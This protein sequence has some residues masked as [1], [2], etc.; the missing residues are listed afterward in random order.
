[1]KGSLPLILGIFGTFA[2]SWTGLT[3]I[4]NAQ[5][6]HLDPQMDEEGNDAYPAP[7][8]GLAERGRK[9]YAANGCVYCHSQQVRADYA[10]SDIERK[11]GERRSAP[12]DYIFERP[13][14]L[15]KRRLGPDLANIG[16][17][18]PAEE[19]ARSRSTAAQRQMPARPRR[20][21]PRLQQLPV[22]L[23]PA[24]LRPLRSCGAGC[25]ARSGGRRCQSGCGSS[26]SLCS[27]SRGGHACAGRPC[28]RRCSLHSRIAQGAPDAAGTETAAPAPVIATADVATADKGEPAFI[29]PPGIT[30]TFTIRAVLRIPTCP[31]TASSTRSA[32]SAAS[33][34]RMR[35][36][37]GQRRAARRL[38]NCPELRCEMPRRLSHVARSIAPLE[39][40]QR[41]CA[42]AR[43]RPLPKA[44]K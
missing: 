4:P 1:M 5:I 12:R 21:I 30:A 27:G 20:R 6:G 32:G 23:R 43:C 33:A 9:I 25:I 31:L 29:P 37:S 38:G 17:R 13:V 39:G 34:R 35:F 40:S 26:S 24:A 11:W 18:A 8:S 19:P 14:L 44:A 15:G 2:F 41:R 22:P 10:G 42:C 7:K 16:K 3:L 36:N 28:T